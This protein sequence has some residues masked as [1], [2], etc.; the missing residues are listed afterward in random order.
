MS[1]AG[2]YG[3]APRLSSARFVTT[4]ESKYH[5]NHELCSFAQLFTDAG[6]W[7]TSGAL[8]FNIAVS[9]CAELS[10]ICF[11]MSWSRTLYEQHAGIW[12]CFYMYRSV[13]CVMI[14]SKPTI[15]NPSKTWNSLSLVWTEMRGN[16]SQKERSAERGL[17]KR[18]RQALSKDKLKTKA[19]TMAL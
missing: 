7:R 15:L 14:I 3:M 16:D 8:M 10:F 6:L 2:T 13:V 18:L 17:G 12:L 9:L 19:P 1:G 4:V 11:S 5:N